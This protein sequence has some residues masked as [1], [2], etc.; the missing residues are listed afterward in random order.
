MEKTD[1]DFDEITSIDLYF[2]KTN[3]PI[4]I[5]QKVIKSTTIIKKINLMLKY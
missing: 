5:L 4:K 1:L 3:H 2:T